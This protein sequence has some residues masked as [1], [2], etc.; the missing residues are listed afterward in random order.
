MNSR[1]ILSQDWNSTK[2]LV[3]KGIKIREKVWREACS[4]GLRS[5]SS[6]SPLPSLSSSELLATLSRSPSES[7]KDDN[8]DTITQHWHTARRPPPFP[9][10]L[11]IL[12][13]SPKANLPN[14]LE[15]K[16]CYL[17]TLSLNHKK[18]MQTE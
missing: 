6:S 2:T 5:R 7:L 18:N 15:N 14:V 10:G 9:S 12:P 11:T 17:V 1:K 8:N 3:S 4:A 13:L 16:R